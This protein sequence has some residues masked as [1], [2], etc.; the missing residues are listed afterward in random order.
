MDNQHKMIKGYRDLSQ[1]EIDLV[2][3]IKAA[4]DVMEG[5]CLLVERH[6]QEAA[7]SAGGIDPRWLAIAR[8][9][10]QKGL[11]ALTRAVT[12]PEGF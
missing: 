1:E 12:K 3:K 6:G 10:L 9:D 2:N 7:R 4:G 11:M 5:V 8:T